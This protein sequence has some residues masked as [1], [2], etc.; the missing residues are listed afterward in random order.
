M[1]RS[2]TIT[3][4]MEQF[5]LGLDIGTFNGKNLQTHTSSSRILVPGWSTGPSANDIIE[6]HACGL[7]MYRFS[8]MHTMHAAANTICINC[9]YAHKCDR[10]HPPKKNDYVTQK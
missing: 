10:C 3:M 7:K 2:R 1:D 6:C 4:R 9:V 5:A 8:N